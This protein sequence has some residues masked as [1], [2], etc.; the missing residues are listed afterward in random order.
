M[1]AKI[2]SNIVRKLLLQTAI[3]V[4][5]LVVLLYHGRFC[6]F[7]GGQERADAGR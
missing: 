7:A 6:C 3:W 2:D 5:C 1:D 4:R